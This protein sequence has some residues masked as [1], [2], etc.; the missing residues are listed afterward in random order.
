MNWVGTVEG[1]GRDPAKEGWL[2]GFSAI[3]D[4]PERVEDEVEVEA[5]GEEE[6][7]WEGE[8]ANDK[9]EDETVERETGWGEAAGD[10]GADL[11]CFSGAP[12]ISSYSN[13]EK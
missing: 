6:E 13:H 10:E 12:S 8:R 11:V 9:D 2:G 3:N 5:E 7:G 1:G 4:P